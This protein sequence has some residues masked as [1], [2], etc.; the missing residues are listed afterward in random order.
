MS[1][2]EGNSQSPKRINDDLEGFV[3]SKGFGLQIGTEAR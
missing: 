3:N 1:F 2:E